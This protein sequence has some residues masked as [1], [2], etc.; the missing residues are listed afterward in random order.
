MNK[1]VVSLALGVFL[2]A[3]ALA[4]AGEMMYS[5]PKQS[6]GVMPPPLPDPGCNCFDSSVNIDLFGVGVF[7]HGSDIDDA[8]GGGIGLTTFVN[9][10]LGFSLNAYWW[11]NDS[12]IHSVDGSVILRAPIVESCISPYVFGGIGGYFDSINQVTYHAGAGIE[13]KIDQ[14]SCLGIFAD[15]AYHW[16]DDTDEY[17][18]ARLGVRIQL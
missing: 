14:A 5:S 6:K 9:P 16:A 7:G 10:Y 4:T 12:A 3:G 8:L 11:D 15:G 18:V 13:V 17:T 1:K 2:G